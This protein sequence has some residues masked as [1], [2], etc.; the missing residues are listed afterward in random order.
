MFVVEQIIVINITC[1]LLGLHLHKTMVQN[2]CIAATLST[3]AVE[4]AT[5]F[6]NSGAM[7]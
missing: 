5:L 4:A 7:V 2:S 1:N 6:E 3:V